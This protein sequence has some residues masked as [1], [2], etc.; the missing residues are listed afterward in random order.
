M[1][2]KSK[3]DRRA[4]LIIAGGRGTRFWPASRNARPKP[5]FS[6]D[7]KTTLIADTIKRH[8][9]LIA[10]ERIFVLV[11]ATQREA[12]AGALEGV[13]PADNLLVEPE[14]RGTTVAIAYGWAII[15]DRLG[16]TMLAVTPADHYV[17]P[18]TGFRQTL[19]QAFDLARRRHAIVVIGVTPTRA[20]SGYGYMKIG[21]AAGNGF[22][23]ERFVEKPA[24]ALAR[25]MVRSGKYLWNAGVFVMSSETLAAELAAHCAALKKI[26][27]QPPGETV[28]KLERAYR[29]LKLDAFDREVVEKSDRVFGVRARFRWHDVGSWHGLWE[30]L[31]DSGGNALMGNVMALES[32]GVLARSGERLV[33]LLGVEDL[34]V[35]DDGDALLVARRSRSQEVRRVIDELERRKLHR[36]L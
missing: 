36:Y 34:V 26:V 31:C 2:A 6:L 14:G 35:V 19:R 32:Q 3:E 10:R 15:R 23:V 16:D 22:K 8:Q 1:A 17:T 7:Q 5:L 29:K 21:A 24:P 27:Q 11:P 13:I 20:D 28:T 12:F 18:G 25:S 33:V 4:A 30:A 9:P